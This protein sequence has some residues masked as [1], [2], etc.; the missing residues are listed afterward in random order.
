MKNFYYIRVWNGGFIQVTK[1][2]FFDFMNY[3]NISMALD[4][5]NMGYTS[6]DIYKLDGFM[7][8]YEAYECAIDED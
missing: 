3:H 2:Q 5:D 6:T 4:H 1:K 7:I 8:G